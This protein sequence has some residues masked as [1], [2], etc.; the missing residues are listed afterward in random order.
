LLTCKVV[1]FVYIKDSFL[2]L[3]AKLLH[4]PHSTLIIRNLRWWTNSRENTAFSQNKGLC[5]W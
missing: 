3:D 4:I 5:Q 2:A 1:N